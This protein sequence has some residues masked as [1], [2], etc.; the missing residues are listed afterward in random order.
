[1][2]EMSLA[3]EVLHIIEQASK[4]QPFIRVKTIWLE[5]GQLSCV[6]AE[7]LRFCFESISQYSIAH[8]AHL[9]IIETP[10]HG[11]CHT[12]QTKV[13]QTTLHDACPYCG[14]YGLEVMSGDMLRIKELEVE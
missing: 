4:Q 7:S 2:H 3:E 8:H 12:C 13:I 6:E 9:E 5:I 11:W 10:G 14:S 1:M